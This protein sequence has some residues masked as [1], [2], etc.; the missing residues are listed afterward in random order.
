[1]IPAFTMPTNQGKKINFNVP[2]VQVC[3]DY[4]DL[5]PDIEQ[6]IATGYLDRLNADYDSEKPLTSSLYWT[7][8]DR[9]AALY[10]IYLY[11]TEETDLSI[12]YDCRC[13][14]RHQ[15]IFDL[16]ELAEEVS[17]G[18]LVKSPVQTLGND[19]EYRIVPLFGWGEQHLEEMRLLIDDEATAKEK[20]DIKVMRTLLQI[21]PV[22]MT[23]APIAELIEHLVSL[24]DTLTVKEYKKLSNDINT[25]NQ[26][27][28]F[29]LQ[30]NTNS[31]GEV[32][33]ITP[34][35]DCENEDKEVSATIK[36]RL[37]IPFRSYDY[38]TTI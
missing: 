17:T 19:F 22:G 2:S 18:D 9:K 35:F 7:L 27:N 34:V 12:G 8:Q 28:A 15:V 23:N 5:P 13:G 1:M 36:S 33:L 25:Y 21:F 24:K 16:Q 30:M 11:I 26:D 3:I 10:W 31:V 32:G 38:I 37:S 6:E 14:E 29:G 20:A 4:A